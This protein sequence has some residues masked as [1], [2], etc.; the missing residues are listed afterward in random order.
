MFSACTCLTFSLSWNKGGGQTRISDGDPAGKHMAHSNWE[1]SRKFIKGI[2]IKVWAGF[3]DNAGP[4]GYILYVWKDKKRDSYQNSEKVSP[5]RGPPYRS[6]NEPLWREPC[7]K[8][9]TFSSFIS[10]W[11]RPSLES[12]RKPWVKRPVGIAFMSVSRTWTEGGVGGSK[13]AKKISITA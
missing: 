13:E 12:N 1:S 6:H 8:C 7:N 4:Q 3:R 10:W 5:G 2:I 9:H 11:G